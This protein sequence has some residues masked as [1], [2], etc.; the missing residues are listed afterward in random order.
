[1]VRRLEKALDELPPAEVA[2]EVFGI[3]TGVE[4]PLL[5]FPM[6]VAE[7]AHRGPILPQPSRPVNSTN[8]AG[9]PRV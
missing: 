6:L 8:R 3:V 7:I 1:M 2:E 5:P 9:V 4:V